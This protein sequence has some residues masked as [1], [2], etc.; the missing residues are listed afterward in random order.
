MS[1]Q[2]HESARIDA[3]KREIEAWA[4]EDGGPPE[5]AVCVEDDD[6]NR[7]ALYGT[8]EQIMA[9]GYMLTAKAIAGASSDVSAG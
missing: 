6:R 1:I 8:P 2:V 4:A 9:A 7:A 3:V 5:V